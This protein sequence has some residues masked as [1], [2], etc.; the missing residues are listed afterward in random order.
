MTRVFVTGPTG[1]VGSAVVT[2]LLARGATVVAGVL[3]PVAP[4]DAW[5]AVEQR[6]FAFGAP[7]GSAQ[8]GAG[9]RR[10]AVPHA[11][12]ADL[13]RPDVPVPSSTPP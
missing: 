2:K 6:P 4:T 11:A 3:E 10:R 9:G 13:R 1:T 5:A 8:D 12:A 7:L